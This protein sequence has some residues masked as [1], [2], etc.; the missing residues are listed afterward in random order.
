MLGVAVW[1]FGSALAFVGRNPSIAYFWQQ[2]KY[3]G[4]VSIPPA[5][6]VLALQWTG[7]DKELTKGRIFLLCVIPLLTLILVFTDSLHHL[8]WTK[9]VFIP[10]G[11]YLPSPVE[12]GVGW[13]IFCVYSYLIIFVGTFLI[14]EGLIRLR[15]IYQKQAVIL[16]IGSFAPWIANASHAFKFPHTMLMD[17]TP[18][19]FII[20]GITYAWGVTHLKLID[21]LPVA[22]D[23][24]FENMKDPVF[25]LDAQ[26]RILDLNPRGQSILN[27]D[28][29]EAIGRE[30]EEVF[31]E[32]DKLI[33]LVR[34]EKESRDEI[35]LG[36]EGCCFDVCISHLYDRHNRFT[37]KIVVLRDISERKT[38]EEELRK[39]KE[40][41]RRAHEELSLAHEQ[42]RD[43]NKSLEEKV[44]ERTAEVEKLLRQKNKF[45][46]QLGHDLKNP[47]NPLMNLLPIIERKER[48]PKSKEMLQVINKNVNYMRDLVTKTIR[49][50]RLNA[51]GTEFYL[52]DINLL[53]VINSVVEKNKHFFDEN[54]VEILNRVDDGIIVKADRLALEELFDNLFANAVKY[55]K[56]KRV[57]TID[58]KKDRGFVTVS[59]KD[60]GIG[61]TEEQIGHIFDEFYKVDQSRHD[62][63]S[64]GLGL[65][66][67]KR[68]V[69]KHG[70]RIWA[71]SP[72]LGEGST[73][74]FT[75]RTDEN[76]EDLK[77]KTREG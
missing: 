23:A 10:V 46:N 20:T 51:P 37:G 43:L 15:G 62:L 16:L 57:I 26:N 35:Y 33:D 61:M 68:I 66:I 5:F 65:S 36:R 14:V 76:M 18:A 71:E 42:L 44:K 1:A 74:Y 45:I 70:G 19:A 50:A 28:A 11:P 55:S 25:V 4:I 41:I 40:K 38:A 17:L 72:K 47:L 53:S 6:L 39:S 3:L 30:A 29:S 56:D 48:D 59:I 12:H 52:K 73:F 27:I 22:R 24:V 63:E 67:C 75:I 13:W 77:E 9:M 60:A 34:D 31:H 54:Q 7:R 32:H 64:S 21:I 2:F 8:I 49:L 69:E 58:A